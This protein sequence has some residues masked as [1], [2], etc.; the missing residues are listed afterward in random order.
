M[1]T[2][3]ARPNLFNAHIAASPSLMHGEGI[4][5]KKAEKL[6]SKE[7]T[8]NKAL[9]LTLGNEPR[10]MESIDKFNLILKEFN[11]SGLEWKYVLM[12]QEFHGSVPHKSI[13]EGLEFIFSGW[14]ISAEDAKDL[15]SIQSHYKS[16]T[17]KFGFTIS[18]TELLLNRLGY[19]V[20]GGKKYAQAIEIFKAN[21][22][23]YPNSENVYD[24][25]G[26]AYERSGNLKLAA[27]NY[28]NAFEKGQKSN[29]RNL[30]IFKANLERV[31]ALLK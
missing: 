10:F 19:Q 20:L 7:S 13:Y 25:L 12:K 22:M 26:E 8:R 18:P 31:Q 15:A 29:S 27:K 28:S 4:V 6:L 30:A 9:Y 24:S 14:Q 1:Y 21:V 17:E 16:Q 2:F 5:I 23:F 11:A 3:V